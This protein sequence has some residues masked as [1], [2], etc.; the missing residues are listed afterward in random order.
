MI[1]L[2]QCL[3]ILQPLLLLSQNQSEYPDVIIDSYNSTTKTK[4]I[5]YG[6]SKVPSKKNSISLDSLFYKNDCYISLPKDSYVIVGFTNN[7]IIDAPNQ[8]DIFIE[9]V[10]GAGEYADVFVSSDNIEYKF[11]G[12]AGNGSINELDLAKIGYTNQVKYIKVVGKDSKGSSPGFDIGSIY[13][14]PGAN[15]S[16]EV[17]VLEN[18]LFETNKTVLLQESFE[19]LNQLVKQL[20]ANKSV[21]IEIR[22]HT[23]N[24]GEEAKNQILSEQRA[25]AVLDYLVSQGIEAK[26]LSYHGFGSTQPIASNDTNEGRTKNRRVE[27]LKVE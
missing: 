27:F 2:F 18:V 9:E 26:R 14:L 16:A 15:K 13:G 1:K 25:K 22:G 3:F 5:F 6:G 10:G 4:N 23:D 17:I 8:N 24:I 11:L 19:T 12:V 20:Q 7:Y 21:Q